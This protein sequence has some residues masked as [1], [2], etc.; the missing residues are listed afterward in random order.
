MDINE[1]CIEMKNDGIILFLDFEK[2]FDF[3]E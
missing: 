1:Y 3:F 2:I